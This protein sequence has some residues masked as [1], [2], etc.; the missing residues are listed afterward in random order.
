MDEHAGIQWFTAR[1]RCSV[2][3]VYALGSYRTVP[4][5]KLVKPGD[6]WCIRTD[7]MSGNFGTCLTEINPRESLIAARPEPLPEGNCSG[8]WKAP[9]LGVGVVSSMCLSMN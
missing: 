5:I 1:L 7:F 4:R 3:L 2:C 6:H 8:A 9:S